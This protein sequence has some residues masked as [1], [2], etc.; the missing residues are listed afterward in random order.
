LAEAL[1]R[2]LYALRNMRHEFD[3]VFIV[4]H[5]DWE[6]ACRETS[7]EDFDLHDYI[8][9]VAASEGICIQLLRDSETGALNYYCRCSVM[10]RLGV[11]LYTKA[12]GVPWVLAD[13][14]PG[15]A[16]IGIDYALRSGA[17]KDSRFA[18]C[19]SQV[20]DAEGSGLE[21]IAYEAEGV[22]LFGKNPFLRRDQMMKVIARSL[23]I[24]QRKHAGEFPRRVVIQKNTEFKGEEVD[25]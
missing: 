6:V 19:C 3:V 24:Y 5:R 25:G 14:E 4:L 8:K 9:A 17:D 1:T 7:T 12:G 13:V 21:F 11:A 16:F 2:A 22:R 10:W 18:I 20:F 15:T 23:A